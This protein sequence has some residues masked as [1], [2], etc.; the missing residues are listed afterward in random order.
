MYL[1]SFNNLVTRSSCFVALETDNLDV[2]KPEL[3]LPSVPHVQCQE[4]CGTNDAT[5]YTISTLECGNETAKFKSFLR[6]A[7]SP[8]AK[9][10]SGRLNTNFL[11][12]DKMLVTLDAVQIFHYF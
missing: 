5:K 8:S 2:S 4:T 10:C 1:S 12:S 3:I 7:F 11:D 6:T 9:T